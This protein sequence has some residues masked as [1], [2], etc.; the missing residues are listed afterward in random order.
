LS[1]KLAI[2]FRKDVFASVDLET[3]SKLL[4]NVDKESITS[5]KMLEQGCGNNTNIA[6]DQRLCEKY[7]RLVSVRINDYVGFSG[8]IAFKFKLSDEEEHLIKDALIKVIFTT[9][10]YL[11]WLLSSV[12][13]AILSVIN[14]VSEAESLFNLQLT[15]N[16]ATEIFRG[17]L[18]LELENMIKQYCVRS[19]KGLNMK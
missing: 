14:L 16:A 3:L 18:E 8:D 11:D 15:P 4:K 2:T 1:I 19:G 7:R 17:K 10:F 9:S 6:L 12:A 5:I 13:T